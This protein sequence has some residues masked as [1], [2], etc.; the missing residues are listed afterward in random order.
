M[1]Q[2][3]VVRGLNAALLALVCAS[4]AGSALAQK[5][6]ELGAET[7]S[8]LENPPAYPAYPAY[9]APQMVPQQ[10]KAAPVQPPP[11][12]RPLQ[13][14][15]QQNARPPQQPMQLQ[16]AV[17]KPAALPPAFL[18]AWQVGGIRSGV[19]AQ[20]AYQ[21]GI[22]GIFQVQNAQTWNIQGNPGSG[23]VLSSDTGVQTQLYVDKVSGNTAFIRYQHPIRNTM[24]QEAIVMQ[25][26]ADGRSFSGLERIS[27]VKQ[28][29]PQPRAK[30]TYQL[31]G[32]RR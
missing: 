15:V 4:F 20:P 30:V 19:E 14:G 6:F 12:R 3:R 18:G 17:Q 8:Y 24:A 7:K 11:V 23:Y 25:L 28:G 9:P 16:A 1:G 2:S 27:I 26:S 32:R 10:P 22:G 31:T 29:E 13:T 21:A 5:T